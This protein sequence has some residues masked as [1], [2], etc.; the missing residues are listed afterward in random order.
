MILCVFIH[1]FCFVFVNPLMV[2]IIMFVLPAVIM[3][4]GV[5]GG[6]KTTSL[7]M[8]KN[9]FSYYKVN[10]FY[11][12][13]YVLTPKRILYLNFIVS[14]L[15]N[16]FSGTFHDPKLLRRNEVVASATVCTIVGLPLPPIRSASM[17]TSLLVRLK[18]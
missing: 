5:N 3:I 12:D 10:I 17:P 6:G 13:V 9:S 14:C 11:K 18:A 15:Y 8:L 4:V 7:G 2:I 1:T 16:F